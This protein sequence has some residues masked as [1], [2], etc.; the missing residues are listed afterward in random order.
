MVADQLPINDI[1]EQTVDVLVAAALLRLVEAEILPIADAWHQLDAVQV[2]QVTAST[3]QL[4][5][6]HVALI[7]VRQ[8]MW[9]H[10]VRQVPRRL[11]GAQVA[12]HGK[13]GKQIGDRAKP[14]A[15]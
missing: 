15:D 14:G 5:Q 11:V 4:L 12:T 6:S 2:G 7:H 10:A 13:D 1:A 9:R 3:V 8:L